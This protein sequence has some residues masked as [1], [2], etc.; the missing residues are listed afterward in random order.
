MP[1]NWPLNVRSSSNLLAPITS[2]VVSET[3]RGQFRENPVDSLAMWRQLAY[4]Y[5]LRHNALAV[6]PSSIRRAR[7][8]PWITSDSADSVDIGAFSDVEG[9]E[10]GN[11]IKTCRYFFA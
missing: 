9:T 10:R 5:E 6:I 1:R 4:P 8:D 2:S 7:N 3:G 11:K